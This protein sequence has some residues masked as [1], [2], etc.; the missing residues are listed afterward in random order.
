MQEFEQLLQHLK[1]TLT[2]EQK[3]ELIDKFSKKEEVEE[4]EWKLGDKA[5]RINSNYSVTPIGIMHEHDLGVV[6]KGDYFHT[7]E[8][9]EFEAER[10]K[11]CKELDK[12][13]VKEVVNG[14]GAIYSFSYNRNTEEIFVDRFWSCCIMHA[15]KTK[16]DAEV[17]IEAVGEER[18]KKYYFRIKED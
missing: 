6:E 5:F 4:S 12:F 16:E 8:E 3:Q 14:I 13:A 1:E 18:L 9:A 2:D 11:V 10:R 7:R 15:F 17:A